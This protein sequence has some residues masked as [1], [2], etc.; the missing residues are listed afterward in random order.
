MVIG[1]W[2]TSTD[3]MDI[4]YH[5]EI[6]ILGVRINDRAAKSANN[7]WSTVTGRIRAQAR[8]AYSRELCL[9]QRILYVNNFL[10]AK[11]MVHCSDLSTP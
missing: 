10:L 5:M 9:D 3:I 1:S 6:R 11:G 2:D 4:Q 8:D 7:S